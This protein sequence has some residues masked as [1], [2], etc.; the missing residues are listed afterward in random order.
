MKKIGFFS[1]LDPVKCFKQMKKQI[2]LLTGAPFSELPLNIKH[3]DAARH[4]KEKIGLMAK[5]YVN[6]RVADPYK[7]VLIYSYC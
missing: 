5:I 1:T 4:C 3:H 2:L 7:D 6:A